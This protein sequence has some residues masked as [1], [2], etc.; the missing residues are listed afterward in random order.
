MLFR[1]CEFV[2]LCVGVFV[3]LSVCVCTFVC[4]CVSLRLFECLYV[5]VCVYVSVNYIGFLRKS[6][7]LLS[8]DLQIP[9]FFFSS[10]IG[11]NYD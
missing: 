6:S 7:D 9:I 3:F 2:S 4:L 8:Q 11:E 10:N 1:V 5:C